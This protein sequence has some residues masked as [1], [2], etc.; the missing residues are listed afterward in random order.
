MI[1]ELSFAEMSEEVAPTKLRSS[2]AV[3]A[4]IQSFQRLEVEPVERILA[5]REL[6]SVCDGIEIFPRMLRSFPGSIEELLIV[7]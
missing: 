4:V 7:E 1:V 5:D 3:K 6:A 2:F